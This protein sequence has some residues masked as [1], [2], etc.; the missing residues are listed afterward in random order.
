MRTLRLAAIVFIAS[1]VA[2]QA[3]A[4]HTPLEAEG[5]HGSLET[6][7][8]I[9]DPTRSWTLYREL[10]GAAEPH[11][12]R[13]RLEPG[14]RLVV[15]LFTPTSEGPGFV[16]RLVVMGADLQAIGSFPTY[17]EVPEGYNVTAHHSIHATPEYEP[18]T[19][20][21]Y[22]FLA[23]VRV[24]PVAGGDYYFAVYGPDGGGRY[25]LTTGYREEFTLE[26]WVTTPLDLFRI[27]LWEGQSPLIVFGPLA[28]AAAACVWLVR[29]REAVIGAHMWL[30]L[31]AASAYVASGVNTGV[32]MLLALAAS[33]FSSGS[34]LTGIFVAS[35]AGLGVMVLQ[36]TLK[37][38]RGRTVPQRAVMAAYGLIGLFIWAGVIVGPVLAL[39][40]AA[41]SDG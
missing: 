19:P 32:Q 40:A 3:V 14:D 39:F 1:M 36:K 16:P 11:Y 31:A 21:S 20:A 4:G 27:R 24:E 30:G 17:V 38:R 23:E 25:G 12:Y 35:Q 9:R 5:E 6:A 22:H 37:E 41:V 29:R 7:L 13:V 15:S 18:F 26:E 33:G 8:E 34:L 2:L 28:A 10:L